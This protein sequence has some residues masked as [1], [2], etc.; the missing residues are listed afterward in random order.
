MQYPCKRVL[1]PLAF[2]LF[3]LVLFPTLARSQPTAPTLVRDINPGLNPEEISGGPMSFV[4]M[5]GIVYFQN[6]DP[7]HGDEIWRTDG[8]E[9]G[10]WLLKDLLPGPRGSAPFLTVVG[11]TLYLQADTNNN[12]ERDL[13]KSDGTTAGTVLVFPRYEGPPLPLLESG[14]TTYTFRGCTQT[15]DPC[16]LWRYDGTFSSAVKVATLTPPPGPSSQWNCT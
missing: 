4:E 16:E 9:E 11:N 14:K 13:W 8:T 3:S 5:G 12:G 6:F 1:Q 2:L 15:G 10:T 7:A